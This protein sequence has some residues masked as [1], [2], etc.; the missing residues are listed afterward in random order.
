MG[1]A[2]VK[3]LLDYSISWFIW[4]PNQLFIQ[5]QKKKDNYQDIFTWYTCNRIMLETECR[6]TFALFRLKFIS[7]CDIFII[8]FL[9]ISWKWQ[10]RASIQQYS[11]FI[12][13]HHVPHGL[14]KQ[15]L[16]LPMCKHIST[17]LFKFSFLNTGIIYRDLKPE[18]ILLQKDGHIVLTDFDLSFLTSSQPQVYNILIQERSL[19][20]FNHKDTRTENRVIWRHILN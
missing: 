20:F 1:V 4:M 16:I 6:I 18:N 11:F 12:I 5:Q 9:F 15:K 3:D 19:I 7:N 14:E 2:N 17:V 8:F 10:Q 13:F